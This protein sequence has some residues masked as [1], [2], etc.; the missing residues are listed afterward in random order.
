MGLLWFLPTSMLPIAAVVLAGAVMLRVMSFGSALLL[1]TALALAPFVID[2]LVDL[3]FD[4]LPWWI[5]LPG[6]TLLLLALLRMVL[7]SLIGA[8]AADHAVGHLTAVGILGLL[9]LVFLPVRVLG[10]VAA[11]LLVG[12]F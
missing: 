2:P 12:K 6:T 8:G 11:R 7:S 4:S 10:W 1:F 3:A 9:R 5:L